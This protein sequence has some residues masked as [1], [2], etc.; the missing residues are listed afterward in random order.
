MMRFKLDKSKGNYRLSSSEERRQVWD[1]YNDMVHLISQNP[2]QVADY[3]E[4]PGYR[5]FP[6]SYPKHRISTEYSQLGIIPNSDISVAGFQTEHSKQQAEYCSGKQPRMT[7]HLRELNPQPAI[8]PLEDSQSG[9]SHPGITQTGYMQSGKP[10]K[11]EFT[12]SGYH[13]SKTPY[14]EYTLQRYPRSQ[15]KYQMY[16]EADN[17]DTESQQ[18]RYS[19]LV[20]SET[21]YAQP[22]YFQ[23]GYSRSV[24]GSIDNI[25]R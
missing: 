17:S 12:Q 11:P 5:H 9:V 4:K 3:L 22:G 13:N 19:Q 7:P 25:H 2:R 15:D 21:G 16:L 8:Q 23:S 10:D 18:S 6:E 20:N 1:A 14:A 24:Y